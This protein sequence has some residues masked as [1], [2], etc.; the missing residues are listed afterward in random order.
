MTEKISQSGLPRDIPLSVLLG[1]ADPEGVDWGRMRAL[2][3]G[4]LRRNGLF[5][6]AAVIVCAVS[7]AT[8]YLN[9]L[10]LCAWGL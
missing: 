1:L 8:C 4:G 6:L 7:V 10:I 5:K 3:F 2:Q 9:S